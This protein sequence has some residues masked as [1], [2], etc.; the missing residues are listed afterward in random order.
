MATLTGLAFL[1]GL[2]PS[3]SPY[4]SYQATPASP[5]PPPEGWDGQC[6]KQEC[7]GW[8]ALGVTEQGGWRLGPLGFL[9]LG[10]VHCDWEYSVWAAWLGVL[11]DLGCR[12]ATVNSLLDV[13]PPSL[14]LIPPK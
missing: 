4:H 14:F 9:G 10:Q 5:A 6:E 7:R 1:Q 3:C 2:V 8:G 12:M 13:L 11:W